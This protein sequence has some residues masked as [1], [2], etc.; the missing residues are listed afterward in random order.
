MSSSTINAAIEA[1]IALMNAAQTMA[2]VRRGALGTGTGIVCELGP[3]SPREVY[4][5]KDAYI[6]LD[7][8]INGKHANLEILSDALNA[9]HS[10]LTRAKSYTSGTNWEIVD[11]TT[12]TLPQIIGREDNNDWIMASSLAVKV[13]Q[14]GD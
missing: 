10:T 6:P 9:I 7:V 4:L 5:S 2:T 3:S 12:T 11:I 1:T 8:T 14:K 13:Y